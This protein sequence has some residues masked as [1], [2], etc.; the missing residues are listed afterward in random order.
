MSD[1]KVFDYSHG[2]QNTYTVES[3]HNLIPPCME[4]NVFTPIILDGN[5]YF[6][7][8][9]RNVIIQDAFPTLTSEQREHIMS[10]IHP[11]CWIIIMG[12]EN[13]E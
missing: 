7:R 10:G 12:D 2:S 9:M 13:A 1:V 6:M 4:C 5:E 8:F 3:R 11:E